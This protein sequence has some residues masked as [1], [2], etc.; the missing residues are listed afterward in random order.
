MAPTAAISQGSKPIASFPTGTVFWV[1]CSATA[2]KSIT[3][4][5][6]G[7]GDLITND[8]GTNTRLTDAL[9]GFDTVNSAPQRITIAG[10]TGPG[11]GNNG[12][13]FCKNVPAPTATDLTFLKSSAT[14]DGYLGVWTL[15]GLYSSITD[16][17]SGVAFTNTGQFVTPAVVT[18]IAPGYNVMGHNTVGNSQGL[19]VTGQAAKGVLFEGTDVSFCA[20]VRFA[21]ASSLG[22]FGVD[23]TT[24]TNRIIGQCA[25]QTSVTLSWVAGGVTTTLTRAVTSLGSTAWHTV[26]WRLNFAARTLSVWVDGVFIGDS[27]AGTARNPTGFDRFWIFGGSN[28]AGET[29]GAAWVFAAASWGTTEFLAAH[30]LI[31]GMVP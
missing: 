25:S 11:A 28:G 16:L 19:T 29:F 12:S 18:D 13:Y 1:A 4:T 21:N 31:I 8:G 27:A 23:N 15:P 30:N 22:C 2:T 6:T 5:K 20:R 3:D 7:T 10:A 26:G 14:T 17:A 24:G 9:G